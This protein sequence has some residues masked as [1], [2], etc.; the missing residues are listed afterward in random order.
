MNS[1][2]LLL[3]I[4]VQVFICNCAV[5]QDDPT[6][7]DINSPQE[8]E[9]SKELK[10]QI[11]ELT[12]TIKKGPPQFGIVGQLTRGKKSRYAVK[13]EDIEVDAKT[14]IFGGEIEIGKQVEA[15]GLIINGKIKQA[16]KIVVASP[17]VTSSNS[18]SKN[19]LRIDRNNLK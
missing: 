5:A 17:P 12:Q 16:R 18:F 3:L 6:N 11:E 2:K 7:L 14:Q 13:G 9:V 8:S 4:I 1:N 19:D 10:R 15:S